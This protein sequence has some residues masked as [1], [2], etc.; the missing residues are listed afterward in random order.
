M[1]CPRCVEEGRTSQVFPGDTAAKGMTTQRF[2]DE[3]GFYH[4]HDTSERVTP[5]RC[6]NGHT[7]VIR[8][9]YRP[10]KSCNYGHDEIVEVTNGKSA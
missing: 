8:S 3:E 5:W 7:G 1:K 2:Y 10:C 9:P 6:S 4:V